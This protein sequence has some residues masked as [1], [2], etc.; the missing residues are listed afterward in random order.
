MIQVNIIPYTLLFKQPAGTSRGVYTTRKVWYV[1]LTSQDKT[2]QGIGECAPLPNL[3][4][5]DC[6]DYESILNGACS[7]L[8]ETGEIDYD[9]LRSFP[10]ILFGLESAL[11]HYKCGSYSFW[12]TSFSRGEKGIPINGL[13]WMGNTE[14]MQKQIAD[15]L[16]AGFRCIKLKIGA[17]NFEE[18]LK[19]L[20][21]IRSNYSKEEL[22]LRVDANG[23]FSPGEAMDKLNRLAELEIHSIEQPIRNG[24]WD[25]MAKLA[26]ISPVPIALDEELIGV[27]CLTEKKKL[28]TNIKPQYI[29]L[30]PSLHGGL[31]GAEEWIKEATNLNIDWW[32]T[33]A[34]ESNIGL[35]V[36]AQWTASLGVESPQ[37]LGTGALYENNLPIPL[38]IR[39]DRLWFNPSGK[40]LNINKQLNL[41]CK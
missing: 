38:E 2:I 40:V 6:P 23:A 21:G 32:I 1:V 4:C 11:L 30:K 37:G 16:E 9:S 5:D 27:N 17:L 20:R 24:Q 3:S 19:V 36:I 34:L 18:E 26:S 13:I 14:S 35:N 22:M 25:E 7:R 29:I 8:R 10:S 33:S 15:K 39:G 28:L 12:N 41:S 31:V